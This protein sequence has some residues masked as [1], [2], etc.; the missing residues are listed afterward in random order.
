[1]VDCGSIYPPPETK[2]L[3]E[4]ITGWRAIDFSKHFLPEFPEM[5]I[6]VFLA[7]PSICTGPLVC[8]DFLQASCENLISFEGS[9][10]G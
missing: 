10:V 8:S 9:D 6:G 5:Y 3:F 1:M 4:E 7:R 2:E